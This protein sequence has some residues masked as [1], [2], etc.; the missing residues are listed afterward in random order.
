[1]KDK[2]ADV[3]IANVRVGLCSWNC[4]CGHGDVLS[5]ELIVGVIVR[6]GLFPPFGRYLGLF[7]LWK[8]INTVDGADRK[9]LIAPAAQF[10]DNHH[11]GTDIEDS[12]KLRRAMTKACITVDAFRHLDAHRSEFPLRI[13]LVSLNAL[14]SR[15]SHPLKCR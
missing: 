2:Y 8:R 12:S 4:W 3:A 9:A 11:I 6:E 14:V 1:V 13:S 5:F 15:A 7:P 10:R